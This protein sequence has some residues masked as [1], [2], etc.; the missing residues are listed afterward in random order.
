MTEQDGIQPLGLELTP[1]RRKIAIVEILVVFSLAVLPDFWAAMTPRPA[2]FKYTIELLAARN[3]PRSIANCA[4]VF[5]LIWRS[6]HAWADFGI[7][8]L[9]FE[10]DILGAIGATLLLYMGYY[11]AFHILYQVVGPGVYQQIASHSTAPDSIFVGP[12][13]SGEFAM[14]VVVALMNGLA[15]EVAMRAYF[16]TRLQQVL[17][18]PGQALALSTILFAGYHIYQG[19][20]GVIGAFVIGLVLGGIFLRFRRLFPVARAHAVVDV[21]SIARM[22][23]H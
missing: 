1:E 7:R 13:T 19:A 10:S 23:P 6:G 22:K 12:Q 5:Y 16:I 15:E 2:G 18:S 3:I 20:F 17:G 21:I 9:R 11:G 4:V 14:L 8:R